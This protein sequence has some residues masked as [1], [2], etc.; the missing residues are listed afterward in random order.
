MSRKP[1]VLVTGASG[2]IGSALIRHLKL[3]TRLDVRGGVRC[4]DDEKARALKVTLVHIDPKQ[5]ETLAVGFK[6]VDRIFINVP[7]AD[8]RDDLCIPQIDAAKVADV[9]FVAIISVGCLNPP[10]TYSRF[11][12]VFA[13]IERHLRNSGL[14]HAIIRSHQFKESI[15][16]HL[17]TISCNGTFYGTL[18]AHCKV[19]TVTIN[20]VA[21]LAYHVLRAPHN[22]PNVVLTATGPDSVNCQDTAEILSKILGRPIR[23]QQISALQFK[24]LLAS[25]GRSEWYIEGVI[26]YQQSIASGPH[27]LAMV[28]SDIESLTGRRPVSEAEFLTAASAVF[29]QHYEMT[30]N[31]LPGVKA[32]TTATTGLS[33]A[34]PREE[35]T[36]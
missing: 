3:D 27:S 21:R 23:Y 10:I 8:D 16:V 4:P 30:T 14:P 19:A 7:S 9:K 20:D 5:P 17:P 11:V 25:L 34:G 28:S 22:Y 33:E 13:S 24:K 35:A 18:P 6:G 32:M 12:D 31:L 2:N 1:V 15:F 29:R 36:A 26:E